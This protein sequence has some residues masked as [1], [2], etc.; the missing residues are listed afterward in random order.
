MALQAQYLWQSRC[1]SIF[2]V[3]SLLF[4]VTDGTYLCIRM[5]G[6]FCMYQVCLRELYV[7]PHNQYTAA[8]QQQYNGSR[9]SR[10]SLCASMSRCMCVC[11]VGA[12]QEIEPRQHCH[13]QCNNRKQFVG[14][15]TRYTKHT[16]IAKSVAHTYHWNACVHHVILTTPPGI[17]SRPHPGG[18]PCTY[19]VYRIQGSPSR[20]G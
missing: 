13:I 8:A 2:T 4:T 14:P 17:S 10:S 3:S 11:V 6:H 15:H 1:N 7:L 9:A 5:S 20:W 12:Q 16:A 18:E 19:T